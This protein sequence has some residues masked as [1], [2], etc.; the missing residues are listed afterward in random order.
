MFTNLPIKFCKNCGLFKP[1]GGF[2]KHK[3]RKF[4][5]SDLC[6]DCRCAK[7]VDLRYNLKVGQR[8]KLL[9]NQNGVCAICKIGKYVSN[10]YTSKAHLAVDHCHKTGQ[11]RGLLCSSC[12]MGLGR[13]KDNI[14][15]LE[16]AIKYLKE[17]L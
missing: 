8:A 12:N 11:V 6:R 13:F 1:T 9:S 7:A 2:H 5:V 16:N 4:N 14:D 10:K 3:G 15:F 17:T